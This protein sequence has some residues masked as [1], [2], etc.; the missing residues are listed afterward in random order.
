MAS[1]SGKTSLR[2]LLPR[3]K[4]PQSVRPPPLPPS[5]PLPRKRKA[6]TSAYHP[7]VASVTDWQQCD[8][9]RP[10]CSACT[11]SRQ[12]C[13]YTTDPDET[14]FAALKRTH[15]E[16]ENDLQE[17][18]GSHHHLQQFVE[19]LKFLDD[20]AVAAIIQKLR[21]GA[22]IA[23]L[24]RDVGT[25]SLLL[26]LRG[27]P[28]LISQGR[29]VESRDSTVATPPEQ[30]HAH[31]HTMALTQHRSQPYEELFD[32]LRTASNQQALETLHRIRQGHDVHTTLRKAKEADPVAQLSLVPETRRLYHFPHRSCFPHFLK[33][34]DNPY[35][36]SH[37]YKAVFKDPSPPQQ[38]QVQASDNQSIVNQAMYTTPF[39]AAKMV[40]PYLWNIKASKWTCV[41]NDDQLVSEL[42]N[43]YFLHQ[44]TIYIG[45]HKDYFL[46][47]LAKGRTQFCSSLLVNT[48]LAA[49]CHASMRIPDRAKFWSPQN[50]AYQFLAEARRLWEIQDGKSSLTAIQAAIVLNIIYDCDTMDKIGRSYL[51]Q[52]VAMAHDLK[53]F[54]S[55]SDKSMPKKTQRARAFTAWCLYA[56]D[57]MHSFHYRLPPL[58]DEPP[59][60]PL[61]SVHEDPSWY[62]EIYVRYPL[63]DTVITTGFGHV[64]KAMVELQQIAHD[65]S[66]HYWGGFNRSPNNPSAFRRRLDDWFFS[67]PEPLTFSNIILPMHLR[68]HLEYHSLL[69]SLT[70]VQRNSRP[71][72]SSET[73]ADY[74]EIGRSYVH[75]ETLIRLYYLHHNLEIFDPYLVIHLLMLG[76]Y[77]IEMLNKPATPADN[78]ELY[79]YIATMACLMLRDRMETRDNALLKTYIHDELDYDQDSMTK[80][81]QSNYPVPIIKIN[82]DPRT[83]LLGNLVKA[84][85]TLSLDGDSPSAQGSTPER[86]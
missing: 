49:A 85:E 1:S 45:F 53:L 75:I 65:I 64:I 34:A 80:Y 50:L 76:N 81:N 12:E 83:V 58:F 79:R 14:R 74:D 20:N 27:R 46:K 69:V 7:I 24:A 36:G 2:P 18:R 61:P 21:Q 67:L 78:A 15:I 4:E 40:D 57:A 44:Y 28:T 42:L 19:A 52:A 29:E 30:A 37:L 82:E 5:A 48:L 41:T 43:T 71:I 6:V 26:Q 22:S 68:I 51:L 62:P 54:Q 23:E 16:L 11:S 63:D 73:E 84:Y 32:L 8:A 17:L 47:D 72:A 35:L 86:L 25:G 13:K 33:I 56:W 10:T 60:F 77:V 55:S 9:N 38:M 70:Q 39:H 66:R 31:A 59:E 3:S